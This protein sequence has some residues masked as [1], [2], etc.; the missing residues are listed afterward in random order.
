MKIIGTFPSARKARHFPFRLLA[1]ASFYTFGKPIAILY[2][3]YRN[4][5][6]SFRS[7]RSFRFSF[8]S[9]SFSHFACDFRLRECEE[10]LDFHYA[11][12]AVRA[13]THGN[14]AVFRLFVADDED[15]RHFF[16]LRFPDF[17]AELLAAH[18]RFRTQPR[19]S[20]LCG[21]ALSGACRTVGEGK[22]PDLFG[23]KPERERSVVFSMS[24][25]SV[26]S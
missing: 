22:H 4:I 15:I 14:H 10:V 3:I 25:A 18:I 6:N 26:R 16:E 2:K 20:E 24:I 8:T 12:V 7:G 19:L 21:N 5:K 23:R 13:V 1:Q 9:M 11:E 17:L